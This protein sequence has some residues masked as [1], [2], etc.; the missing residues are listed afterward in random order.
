VRRGWTAWAWVIVLAAS[1]PALSTAHADGDKP[2]NNL[3]KPASPAPPPKREEPKRDQ[4]TPPPPPARSDDERPR[5]NLVKPTPT[6]SERERQRDRERRPAGAGLDRDDA[7]GPP[8]SGLVRNPRPRRPGPLD[9]PLPPPRSTLVQPA[10][11]DLD[12]D[13]EWR[14]RWHD[15][16]RFGSSR[17]HPGW[18]RGWSGWGSGGGSGWGC[19]DGWSRRTWHAWS[20][21]HGY[22]TG[23]SISFHGSSGA[24]CRRS[25]CVHR[26][27]AWADP[28]DDWRSDPW[29]SYRDQL[30]WYGWTSPGYGGRPWA[31]PGSFTTGAWWEPSD[32]DG[33]DSRLDSSLV[34]R[35]AAPAWPS[36]TPSEDE[37]SP[38][39]APPS[40]S[41]ALERHL[42][43]HAERLTPFVLSAADHTKNAHYDEAVGALRRAVSSSP[44]T[45][46]AGVMIDALGERPQQV[47]DVKYALAILREPPRRAVRLQ[48]AEFMSAALHAALGETR[49]ARAA[50]ARAQAA[51]DNDPSTAALALALERTL[52]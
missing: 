4:P 17:W 28:C 37:P 22:S 30:R 2:R 10:R 32:L 40:S 33:Y 8:R 41:A 6:P 45:F 35:S 24:C 36:G 3:V 12:R 21:D 11:R 16:D 50:V 49:E 38:A 31:R 20:S 13:D 34:D 43:F 1:G 15:R 48:D 47:Q 7:D 25:W 46:A 29:W 26:P 9:D 44:E 14:R 19:D 18:G 5:N 23:W 52:R 42:R 27:R 51:G 39:F